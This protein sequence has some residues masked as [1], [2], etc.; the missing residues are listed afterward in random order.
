MSKFFEKI[1]TERLKII[2][3]KNKWLP[4]FQNGFRNDR[5]TIDNLVILQQ[6]IHGSFKRN[7]YLLAV[8]LDVE[9]A[10]DS[11]NRKKLLNIL[12]SK[13]VRG[14]MLSYL[15]FFLSK[16]IN[17]VKFKTENSD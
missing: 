3:K 11:V 8:F 10:Y 14:K 7:E 17:R 4:D 5:S 15:K 1:V 9:Q 12:I 13:G 16:R 2:V 6:E